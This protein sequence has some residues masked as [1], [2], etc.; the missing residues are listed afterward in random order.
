MLS[1]DKLDQ[2]RNVKVTFRT[3]S[4]LVVNITKTEDPEDCPDTHPFFISEVGCSYTSEGRVWARADDYWDI[5]HIDIP[6]T[7]ENCSLS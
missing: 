5:L 6:E 4:S 3:G 7:N 1:L 2:Y